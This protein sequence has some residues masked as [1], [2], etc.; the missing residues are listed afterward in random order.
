MTPA[1]TAS[2]ASRRGNPVGLHLGFSCEGRGD[3]VTEP[4]GMKEL[5]VAL[6]EEFEKLRLAAISPRA[7]LEQEVKGAAKDVAAAA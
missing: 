1:P 6:E 3:V 7:L 5:V 4:V 2:P